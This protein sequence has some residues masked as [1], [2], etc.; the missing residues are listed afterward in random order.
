MNK[1]KVLTILIFTLFTLVITAGHILN[2]RLNPPRED[3]THYTAYAYNTLKY[4]V[5]SPDRSEKPKS[6]NHR[7]PMYPITLM[8]GIMLHPGIDLS[9]HNAKCISQGQNNCEEMVAYLKIINIIFLMLCAIISAYFVY[10]YTGQRWVSFI[11]F[12]FISL[13]GQL[14][15]Y[16][17][18]YYTETLAALLLMI[19]SILLYDLF[20]KGFTKRRAFIA[21]LTLGALALTKAIYLYFVYLSCIVLFVL[22]FYHKKGIRESVIRVSIFLLGTFILLAPWFA[23]NYFKVGTLSMV[24]GRSGVNLIARARLNNIDYNEYRAHILMSLPRFSFVKKIQ[25]KYI[26]PELKKKLKETTYYHL[27][28][29]ERDNI[30]K[31]TGLKGAG[32]NDH[33]VDIGIERILDNFYNHLKLIPLVSLTSITKTEHGYGF[34][35]FKRDLSYKTISQKYYNYDVGKIYISGS[36]IINLLIYIFSFG[37]II[38]SLLYKRWGLFCFLLPFAF[39]FA[40]YAFLTPFASRFSC[41]FIPIL[42]VATMLLISKISLLYKQKFINP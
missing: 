27:S 37:L 19:L 4:G 35:R 15:R 10:R 7:E 42:I 20:E 8:I 1:K 23:H 2:L 11:C 36:K 5:Y 40:M 41:H 6:N 14:G 17:G 9:V 16:T 28:Y 33:I 38:Y 34:D 30:K 39:C 29:V 32:L 25:K 26:T 22:W 13:S 18:K 31:E 21:G 24:G 3:G 12:L